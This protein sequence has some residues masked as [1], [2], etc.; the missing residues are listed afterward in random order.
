[1]R[2]PTAR[3][4]GAT[5]LIA[6]VVAIAA[7][8]CSS[9]APDGLEYVA[10]QQGFATAADEHSRSNVPMAGYNTSLTNS[11]VVNTVITGVVGA[12]IALI[13]GLAVFRLTLRARSSTTNTTEKTQR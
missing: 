7:S 1:M 8:R 9:S 11:A 13:L 4:V 6:G 5:L 10:E 2:S 3:L 12:L